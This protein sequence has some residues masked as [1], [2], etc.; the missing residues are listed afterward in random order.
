MNLGFDTIGNAII[1]AYDKKP[2]LVTDPWIEGDAYFGSWTLSHEIPIEQLEAIKAAEYIWISH[3]HPDHLSVASLNLLKGSTILMANH[4]G[5]RI[6]SD[7]RRLGFKVLVLQ[8]RVWTNLSERINIVTV[9]DYNQDSLLMIDVGGKLLVNLND[10]TAKG[11]GP[12]VQKTIRQYKTSFLLQGFGYGDVDMI[13]FVDEDGHRIDPP[14]ATGDPVGRHI[15]RVAET[16]GVSNVI[17]FSSLHKYQRSDS[18]WAREY[19]TALGDYADGFQ[20]QRCT[21]LPAYTRYDCLTDIP[22][23][24]S[25]AETPDTVVDSTEFGDDWGEPLE[26]KDI[27]KIRD[28]FCAIEKL[29]SVMDFVTLKVGGEEHVVELKNKGFKKGIVFEVPR[30]SLMRAIRYEIFDDL[31]IGNFMRTRLIGDWPRSG[32]YPDFTPFVGKYADNGRAKTRDEVERYFHEYRRRAPLDYLRHRIQTNTAQAIKTRIDADSDVY[33][34][35][36][37]FWWF[38]RRHIGA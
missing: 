28:Y 5:G 32:L 13:N 12:F 26:T 20:S 30:H 23:E 18:V 29:Q 24:I 11:W 7:L 15:A 36:Q 21:L 27:T 37:R 34:T 2:V 19:A 22:Q 14:N 3:G 35:A 16:Y 6:A 33:R 38:L 10:M 25:P 1:V 17:P 9:P 8:D 31:L 4:V